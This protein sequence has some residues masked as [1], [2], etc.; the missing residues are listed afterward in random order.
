MNQW[1]SQETS[2]Y[3][4]DNV[5]MSDTVVV[6][7]S[8][9]PFWVEEV[10]DALREEGFHPALADDSGTAY[11]RMENKNPGILGMPQGRMKVCIV[12][13]QEEEVAARLFLRKRDEQFHNRAAELTGG[14]R[15]PLVLATLATAVAFIILNDEAV[16][17]GIRYP[18]IGSP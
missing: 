9:R 18:T 3:D 12:V 13:P 7:E 2:N 8:G 17:R 10:M 11:Y 6:Y 1:S 5:A 4:R 16:L 15:R 14:L